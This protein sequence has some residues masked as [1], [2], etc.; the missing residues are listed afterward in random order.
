MRYW[1]VIWKLRGDRGRSSIERARLMASN[2]PYVQVHK[3]G[4][5]SSFGRAHDNFGR[6]FKRLSWSVMIRTGA[7]SSH[8]AGEGSKGIVL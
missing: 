6:H 2:V 1:D 7:R 5:S 8:R 4:F 3:T